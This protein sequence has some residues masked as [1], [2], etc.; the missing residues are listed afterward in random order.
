MSH[1]K[2]TW[3]DLRA[4][5]GIFMSYKGIWHDLIGVFKLIHFEKQVLRKAITCSIICIWFFWFFYLLEL[6][7]EVDVKDF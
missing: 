1:D 3:H 2:G 5:G 7:F 4:I 6:N